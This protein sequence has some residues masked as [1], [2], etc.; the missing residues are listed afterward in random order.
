MKNKLS[1]LNNHLFAQIERLGEEALDADQIKA[2][3]KRA[4]A[5]VALSDQVLSIANTGLKA[6]ELFAKHGD[7][8]LP[9]LPQIG[10]NKS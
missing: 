10:S 9:H 6:A 2:E 4:D 7:V 3:V 1:D 5:L 8:V